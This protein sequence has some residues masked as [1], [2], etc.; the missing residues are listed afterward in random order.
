MSKIGK[1][2]VKI[3]ENVEVLIEKKAHGGKVTING[4]KGSLSQEFD[5]VIMVKNQ[6]GSI[7][8]ERKNDSRQARALQGT[9]RALLNNMVKGVTEGYQRQLV[10]HG[11]GFRA[12]VEGDQLFLSLGF[13]H[14][15]GFKAPTGIAFSVADDKIIISGIDKQLVGSVADRIRK[16]K[17]PEPYKGKGIRYLEEKIKKKVGKKAVATA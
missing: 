4:P 1:I 10:L 15:V 17:P 5:E 12:A 11:V 9:I 6:E 7:L 3:P 13:S 16:I 8:V 2:P 14:R